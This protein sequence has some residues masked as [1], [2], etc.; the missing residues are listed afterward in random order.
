MSFIIRVTGRFRQVINCLMRKT[1][2]YESTIPLTD[3]L[4]QQVQPVFVLSTG[5]CGTKWLT[6]LLAE[7]TGVLVNH[8]LQPELVRQSKLAYENWQTHPQQ[9]LEIVR[10]ARDDLISAANSA[11]RTYIETNNRITFFAWQLIQAYPNSK[12]IH[13]YRHPADFVR[14]GMRRN[15]YNG[16]SA[17]LGRITMSDL[18]KWKTLSQF[19]K[20][21]W[22]WNETNAFISR[23][24]KELSPSHYFIISSEV[25]FSDP[26]R[27][28]A[29]CDFMQVKTISLDTIVKKQTKP[30]NVQKQGD[31]PRYEDW[32]LEQQE[33]LR[34]WC[35]LAE[36]YGY[37]LNDVIV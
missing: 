31:F 22:L 37:N 26:E 35:P 23:F 27:V 14:S 7:Q 25:L 9:Q 16:S 4:A 11:H 6:E 20:I 3:T 21:A 15:W 32:S 13:L 33:Q 28:K 2:R 10:A 12:F 5:R 1:V 34:A 17:D 29:L 8:A 36:M 19:E 24:L 30:V 18:Q